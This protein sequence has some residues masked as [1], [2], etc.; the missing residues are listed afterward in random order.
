VIPSLP[1]PLLT[2]RD[3]DVACANL[4]AYLSADYAIGYPEEYKLRS[5]QPGAP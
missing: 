1:E 2:V 4:T 3:I 5:N